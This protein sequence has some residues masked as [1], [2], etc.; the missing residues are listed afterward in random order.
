MTGTDLD[1]PGRISTAVD[2]LTLEAHA[3]AV[4]DVMQERVDVARDLLARLSG[5]EPGWKIEDDRLGSALVTEPKPRPEIVDDPAWRAWVAESYPKRVAT[6]ERVNPDAIEDALARGDYRAELLR[7]VLAEIPG[8][9]ETDTVIDDKLLA[10][11][12]KGDRKRLEA[13]LARPDVDERELIDTTTGETVPGVRVS[14]AST[15]NL[16]VTIDKRTRSE[17]ADELRERLGPLE[18][19]AGEEDPDA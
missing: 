14:L 12:Y 2:A 19:D 7:E 1:L 3:L 16:R 15:P 6:V 17:L 18:L 4:A 11:I 8:A 5:H 13:E 10:E 9:L